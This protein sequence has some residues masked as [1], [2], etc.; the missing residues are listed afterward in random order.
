MALSENG[1]TPLARTAGQRY[2]RA[3]ETGRA[4]DAGE[5]AEILAAGEVPA[6]EDVAAALG[7]R[8]GRRWCSG[9]A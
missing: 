1:P 3:R 9:I 8:P 7:V 2:R 5:Y 4:Y 6:P